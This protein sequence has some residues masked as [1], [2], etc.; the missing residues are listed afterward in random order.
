M[1]TA[2]DEGAR[3]LRVIETEPPEVFTRRR[4]E[5][6]V[7]C[8]ATLALGPEEW[9]E[10]L[11]AGEFSKLVDAKGA[12]A[13]LARVRERHPRIYDAL[14]QSMAADATEISTHGRERVL[15]AVEHLS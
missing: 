5:H 4:G 3:R 1:D 9:T 10:L 6:L 8:G 2:L 14:V 15:W 12:A 11:T 7:R 13:Y